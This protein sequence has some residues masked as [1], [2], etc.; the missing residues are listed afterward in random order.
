[1]MMQIARS[2]PLLIFI[3]CL[4]GLGGCGKNPEAG[5]GKIYR[6]NFAVV[7]IQ[8]AFWQEQGFHSLSSVGSS[9]AKR[10][11]AA[12]K[13]LY[14]RETKNAD[15]FFRQSW[16]VKAGDQIEFEKELEIRSTQQR[17]FTF[18]VGWKGKIGYRGPRHF[19]K[20]LEIYFDGNISYHLMDHQ[21]DETIPDQKKITIREPGDADMIL[22][23]VQGDTSI[24]TV[25]G[26]SENT[27]KAPWKLPQ[28]AEIRN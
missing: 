16:Y 17:H 25:I 15:F 20:G 5:D 22:R 26:L 10:K 1:M 27:A 8:N 7:T 4:F 12:A 9:K 14:T 19:F 3:A 2:F 11:E 21:T 13:I 28:K 24:W 23:V 6:L 18:P